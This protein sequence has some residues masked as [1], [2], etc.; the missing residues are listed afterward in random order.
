MCKVTSRVP[1]LWLP[2]FPLFVLW[3]QDDFIGWWWPGIKLQS[4]FSFLLSYFLITGRVSQQFQLFKII[5]LLE[6][7]MVFSHIKLCN[8]MF[9]YHWAPGFPPY[10]V[11]RL[12]TIYK[13]SAMCHVLCWIP[14]R[15]VNK[16]GFL[17]VVCWSQFTKVNCVHLFPTQCQW[18]HA[19]SLK[20]G[21]GSI[22]TK[23]I[24][25][26]YK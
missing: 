26:C 20:S 11:N 14:D 16:T 10:S 9:A 15:T 13:A 8:S 25:K 22:Y 2:S 4:N 6:S 3:G 5:L 17:S 24:G 1:G 12:T 23:E 7:Q 21:I 19:G 18:H